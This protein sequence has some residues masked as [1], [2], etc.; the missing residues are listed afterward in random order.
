[1]FQLYQNYIDRQELDLYSSALLK[2]PT[3]RLV[4]FFNGQDKMKNEEERILRLSDAF[5]K[6][7]P[8]PSLECRVRVI[9]INFGKN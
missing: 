9:N 5:E 7:E 3:P 8:E 6:P 1:M 2:I 4:V